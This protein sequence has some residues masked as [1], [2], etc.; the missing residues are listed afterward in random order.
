MAGP[1]LE[2][3]L[4]TRRFGIWDRVVGYVR[5][6]RRL[7]HLKPTMIIGIAVILL[8]A[9]VSFAAPILTSDSPRTI[10]MDDRLISP[11]AEQWF[12]T[13]EFGRDVFSRTLHG[14]RI[15][16]VIGFSVAL[17]AMVLGAI[18]G[19]VAGY[20]R[21]ADAVIMRVV[22]GVMAI[23]SIL[24]AIA[25]M[26]TLGASI[27]NVII[28]LTIVAT[29]RMT[30]VARAS[31]LSLREQ[32]FVDAARSIGAGADRILLRHI[33]PNLLA[34]L[35]VMGTFVTAESILNEAYLS[36]LGAGVPP[37]TPSW[38]NIMASGRNFLQ[39]AMWVILFPGLVLAIAVT[40]VNIA[41]DGLRDILDPKLA[42]R[43]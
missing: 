18:I 5:L 24:L 34:P 37:T 6:V 8:L 10:V 26:A 41:G 2:K 38:G 23:P 11:G 36:F 29:P 35:V 21:R 43:Q 27:Q 12:G 7:S 32:A 40:A 3:A 42:R 16:L 4:A 15:S 22:D 33:I 39:K 20:F 19:S 31:V 30:R 28:A 1:T 25:L 13:D 14:G 17:I 9:I